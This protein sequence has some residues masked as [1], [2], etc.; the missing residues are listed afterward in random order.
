MESSEYPRMRA[1]EDAHWRYHGLRKLWERALRNYKPSVSKIADIGCG[2][3]ANAVFAARKFSAQVYGADKNPLAVGLASQSFPE[4]PFFQAQAETLPFES[5]F[6][7]AAL[8]LDVLYAQGIDEA[9]ALAE[10]ARILKPDGVLLI[11]LPAFE[12]LRG[13]HDRAVH[14]RRRYVRKDLENL[15]MRAGFEI[16][17]ISYWNFF[18]FPIAFAARALSRLRPGPA[19]SD[20]TKVF[21]PLNFL[22][23]LLLAAERFFFFKTGLPWGISVFAAARK[24][25]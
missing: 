25:A 19:Q 5:G 14:T 23:K 21:P 12:C 8:C 17:K 2:T 16:I 9:A 7:D 10:I 11:N 20:V 4:L 3:G 15:L 24:R 6:F 18:L 22:F 13:S 1:C